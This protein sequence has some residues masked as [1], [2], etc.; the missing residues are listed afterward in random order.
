MPYLTHI[1]LSS[2][3]A[4]RSERANV[5]DETLSVVAPWLLAAVASGRRVPLPVEPLSHYSAV[6]LVQDG[7]LVVTLY[8]PQGPH[9]TGKPALASDGIPLV[10]LAVAQRSRHAAKLWPLMVAQFGAKAGITV[11]TAPW[12]A[13]A[14]HPSICAH[15]GALDWLGD[16]ERCIAWAWITR[17]P[18]LEAQP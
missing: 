1:T 6:A 10:T 2:G 4:N 15:M 17:R 16:L 11:P 8:G 12:C 14:V 7:A 5:S 13:V 9:E 18:S 3:H